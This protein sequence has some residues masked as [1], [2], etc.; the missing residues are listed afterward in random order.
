MGA[1]RALTA[2]S[3]LIPVTRTR[4]VRPAS[5]VESRCVFSVAPGTLT[6]EAPLA[7][8]RCHWYEWAMGGVTGGEWAVE[9]AKDG[10]ESRTI[11]VPVC[12]PSLFHS[13]FPPSPSVAEK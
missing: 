10:Y 5:A 13:S 7:L 2:P 4:I 8:Q 9:F 11:T 1:E 12:V 6:H 3:A